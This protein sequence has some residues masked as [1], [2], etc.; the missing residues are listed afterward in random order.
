L[1]EEDKLPTLWASHEKFGAVET[2]KIVGQGNVKARVI[3]KHGSFFRHCMDMVRHGIL[4]GRG[5]DE[6]QE[7]V[8]HGV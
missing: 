1:L 6:A 4:R 8:W 5:F 3:V 2:V 7:I